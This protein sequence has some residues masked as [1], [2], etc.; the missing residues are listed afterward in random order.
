MVSPGQHPIFQNNTIS[1]HL[2][3]ALKSLT[4]YNQSVQY[5]D[6]VN[7]VL[8]ECFEI[9]NST[10]LSSFPKSH[11]INSCHK[12]YIMVAFQCVRAA[13][14]EITIGN[15]YTLHMCSFWQWKYTKLIMKTLIL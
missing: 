9:Y 8:G 13:T 7:E 5:V 2:M 1:I 4:M 15:L 11:Y 10:L 3:L 14:K 12:I 6:K